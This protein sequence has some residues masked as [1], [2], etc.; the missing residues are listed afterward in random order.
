MCKRILAIAMTLTLLLSVTACAGKIPEPV[1]TTGATIDV[2]TTTEPSY[3]DVT[4]TESVVTTKPT[5]GTTTKTT[6]TT[7]G[8]RTTTTTTTALPTTRSQIP[9]IAGTT[10]PNY[11][12]PTTKR[13]EPLPEIDPGFPGVVEAYT[14]ELREYANFL[15][16]PAHRFLSQNSSSS[17]TIKKVGDLWCAWG[18]L[19]VTMTKTVFDLVTKPDVLSQ[20]LREKEIT[21]LPQSVALFNVCYLHCA[22]IKTDKQNVF[23]TINEDFDAERGKKEP[24]LRVY[25][26][27]EYYEKFSPMKYR[28]IVNG[29][30]ITNDNCVHYFKSELPG[31]DVM[32]PIMP[33]LSE[34]GAQFISST[35]TRCDF[36]F[37]KTLLYV[38]LKKEKL[39]QY[40][41]EVP[42]VAV[43]GGLTQQYVYGGELLMG[44]SHLRFLL[45]RATDTWDQATHDWCAI[46]E[47]NMTVTI[48]FPVQN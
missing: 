43:L 25:T 33:I 27:Q 8:L 39:C 13:T 2:V 44:D 41:T 29:K 3:T 26:E 48:N 19:D 11:T 20:F 28:L 38:D 45:C 47:E 35:S 7:G 40:G 1:P 42:Y 46:D 21:D 6:A 34:L 5:T 23:I 36:R 14:L 18:A 22:W 24:V 4:T 31:S 16:N 17:Q 10:K 15:E 37:G 32:L 9:G 30:D 12:I